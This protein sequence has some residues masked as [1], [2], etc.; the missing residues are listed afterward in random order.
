MDSVR[1]NKQRSTRMT[2]RP[3]DA[4]T[5]AA[6]PDSPRH[7]LTPAVFPAVPDLVTPTT[8]GREEH[9]ID[10]SPRYLA[11]AGC[12]LDEAMAPLTDI[13]GWHRWSDELSNSHLTSPCGR[14]Y[15]G[16]LPKPAP[17]LVGLWKAWVRPHHHGARSWMAAF[18][19]QM[20][21]E[22]MAALTAS[23]AE[24]YNPDDA[25]FA[26]PDDGRREGVAKVLT[27]LRDAGWDRDP[28]TVQGSDLERWTAPDGRAGLEIRIN[29]HG[30]AEHEI[31][32]EE[33]RWTV[34]AAQ[35]PYRSPLWDAVFS[36]GTPT[37][38]IAAFCRALVHS[39]PLTREDAQIPRICR[40]LVT[41]T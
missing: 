11:G 14:A 31:L 33:P 38:L 36:T 20:P 39:A 17:E 6:P 1:E 7:P 32:R 40:D 3:T 19:N 16:F 25:S 8:A 4:A 2:D 23:W 22:F 41:R 26:S 21:Y 5:C 28:N 35:A 13:A 10:V 15:L 27:V 12:A 34:W 24:S 37:G 29:A 30:N 18:S 9:E